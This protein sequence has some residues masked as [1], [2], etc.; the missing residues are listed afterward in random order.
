MSARRADHGQGSGTLSSTFAMTDSG[1]T[2]SA[3]AW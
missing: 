2:S 1:V 3:S